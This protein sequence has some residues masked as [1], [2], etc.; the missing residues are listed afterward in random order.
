MAS[1][2]DTGMHRIIDAVGAKSMT[3]PVDKDGLR[4]CLELAFRI[5][6]DAVQFSSDAPDKAQIA[7]F[8]KIRNTAKRLEQL[9][10]PV[11]IRSWA[12]TLSGPPALE[13][14][15]PTRSLQATFTTTQLVAAIDDK[16]KNW[17][18]PDERYALSFKKYNPFDWMV[19]I[20]LASI[21]R[22]VFRTAPTISENGPFVR[23]AEAAL[24]ELK[25]KKNNGADYKRASILKSLRTARADKVRR[26]K[27]GGAHQYA[28]WSLSQVAKAYR[29]SASEFRQNDDDNDPTITIT[30]FDAV[31]DYLITT[32]NPGFL[33]F[34]LKLV[35]EDI[36]AGKTPPG[37]SVSEVLIPLEDLE[38]DNP[39]Q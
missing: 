9:I 28:H 24:R 25:I 6:S 3:Y 37:V 20:Y 27:T 11:D 4:G 34:L 7:R 14:V 36:D 13:F 1:I 35:D 10:G 15:S 30:D 21:Y 17:H 38:L 5:Y 2:S 18:K 23:F 39:E 16:L 8:G 26:R 31:A 19:G 12:L 29:S 32:Q 22:F 33:A